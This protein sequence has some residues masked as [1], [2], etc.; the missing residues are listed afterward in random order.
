MPKVERLNLPAI[1]EPPMHH[2]R[3]IYMCLEFCHGSDIVGNCLAA[4]NMIKAVRA[5]A[6]KEGHKVLIKSRPGDIRSGDVLGTI[7]KVGKAHASTGY[8]PM[9]DAPF[10]VLGGVVLAT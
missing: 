8:R 1:S 4:A 7:V 9:V 6:L 10:M 2:S 5:S 3:Q